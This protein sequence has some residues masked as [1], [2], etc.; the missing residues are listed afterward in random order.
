MNFSADSLSHSA[1][2]AAVSEMIVIG[3]AIHAN[4]AARK[5]GG[6]GRPR[7]RGRR[8]QLGRAGSPRRWRQGTRRIPR[9]PSRASIRS[10]LSPPGGATFMSLFVNQKTPYVVV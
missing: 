1:V 2:S 8:R 7:D 6:R 3:G 9:Q 10:R 5:V 4:A